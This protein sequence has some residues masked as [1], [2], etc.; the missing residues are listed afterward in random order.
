[1]F[2]PVERSIR[3]FATGYSI[4]NIHAG[5]RAILCQDW[6]ECDLA[7]A[8]LAICAALWDVAPVRSFLDVGCSIWKTL[9][10]D[11]ARP[12]TPEF[13]AVGPDGT[14]TTFWQ[15]NR[16]MYARARKRRTRGQQRR[17]GLDRK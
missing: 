6:H 17:T 16:K 3:V 5:L 9:T 4:E 1:M 13:K 11:Y 8:H 15:R 14:A 7:S 10:E 2:R 12:L